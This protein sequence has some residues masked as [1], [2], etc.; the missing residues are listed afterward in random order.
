MKVVCH[1]CLLFFFLF[2]SVKPN[3]SN[4]IFISIDGLSKDTLVALLNKDALPNIAKIVERGNLRS[5]EIPLRHPDMMAVYTSFF[6]GNMPNAEEKDP[7]KILP[8]KETLFRD[9]KKEY[10]GIQTLVMLSEPY[11]EK[12]PPQLSHLFPKRNTYIDIFLPYTF[13][14]NETIKEDV[15]QLLK[16][17]KD[18]FFIFMNITEVDR[19][20]HLY[21]EGA[22]IYSNAVREADKSIGV[23]IDTLIEKD[24]W[25]ETDILLTTSHGYLKNSQIES[26]KSWIISTRK[27]ISKG[28]V[29]NLVPTI[30]DFFNSYKKNVSFQP[31]GQSLLIKKEKENDS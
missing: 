2:L 18:P 6:T 3:F 17:T 24:I 26:S 12:N 11:R 8:L 14:S 27:V 20:G 15:Y 7:D 5:L 30:Y 1:T 10:S 19:M 28:S 13:R 29:T 16:K 31:V 23:I 22:Q 9:L 21:R 25:L 4:V